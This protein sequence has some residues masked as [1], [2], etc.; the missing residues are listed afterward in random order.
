[1]QTYILTHEHTTHTHKHINIPPHTYKHMNIPQRDTC[2]HTY[3]YTD[4]QNIHTHKHMKYPHIHIYKHMN[5]P[6]THNI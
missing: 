1:M 5:I 6:H 3:K 4:I 2:T